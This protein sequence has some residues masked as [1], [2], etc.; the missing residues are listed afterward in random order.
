MQK[1]CSFLRAYVDEYA[2]GDEDGGTAVIDV[3]LRELLLEGGDVGE[4]CADQMIVFPVE[5]GATQ[6][7]VDPL[8]ILRHD[9][10]EEHAG[11]LDKL[12]LARCHSGEVHL[13]E[14]AHH[15]A[16]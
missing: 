6:A 5:V 10:V 4:V 13:D 1:I 2:F 14:V 15:V 9:L 16:G 7:H 12:A 8:L 3:A 11:L